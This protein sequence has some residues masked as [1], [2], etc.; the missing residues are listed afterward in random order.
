MTK[1]YTKSIS[2]TINLTGTRQP[3][4]PITTVWHA[5]RQVPARGRG[6]GWSGS[7]LWKTN[8]NTE[9]IRLQ[10]RFWHYEDIVHPSGI[11]NMPGSPG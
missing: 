2:Q 3:Q 8:G 10:T 5:L 4:L 9:I 7:I 11:R 6:M 1:K